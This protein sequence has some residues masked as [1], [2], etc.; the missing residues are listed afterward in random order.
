MLKKGKGKDMENQILRFVF[1]LFN[2]ADSMKGS[3]VAL[4]EKEIRSAGNMRFGVPEQ[5]YSPLAGNL[6]SEVNK[7][8]GWVK[9]GQAWWVQLI[10][11]SKS[12]GKGG[13]IFALALEKGRKSHIEGIEGEGK[14]AWRYWF[15][16]RTND[17]AELKMIINAK[18]STG[19]KDENGET[20]K[21]EEFNSMVKMIENDSF[22]RL[23]IIKPKSGT[24]LAFGKKEER[25]LLN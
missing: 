9:C 12:Y 11:A 3:G 25:D 13:F 17:L 14:F 23:E 5:G 15:A 21:T 20:I 16:G 4:I 18:T 6:Y 8:N 7:A 19:K 10:D 1:N 22:P 2:R 24:A